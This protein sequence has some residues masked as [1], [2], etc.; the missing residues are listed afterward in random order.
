MILNALYDYYHRKTAEQDGQLAPP[1]FE[2]KEIPFIIQV[3]K[4]GNLIQIEDTREGEGKKKIAKKFLLPQGEKK[5]SNVIANLFWDNAEYVLGLNCKDKPERIAKQHQA[6]IARLKSLPTSALEDI[7]LQAMLLFLE[8]LNLE[9][10]QVLP[11]W[12]ALKTNPN[13]TFRLQGEPQ[14]ICQR[15]A[16][17][18][19]LSKF[20]TTQAINGFCLIS[21]EPDQIERLHTSIKGVRGTKSSG[22]NIVS[23]N[24]DSFNSYN[25]QQGANAPVGKNAVFA[26]TTALNHLLDKNSTQRLQVGDAST[27]FWSEKPSELETQIVDIFGEPTKDEPDR[28]TNAL[29]S[30]YQSINHGLLTSPEGNQRFHVLGLSPNA[31]RISIRFWETA[32]IAEL[33]VRIKQHFDDLDI[34]HG[35][36][37]LPHL[38]L[39][40]LLVSTISSKSK[41]DNIPPNLAGDTLRAILTGLPYPQ[42]LLAA[43]V[44]RNR[45][46]REITYPR[47]A[48]IKACI[49]RNIRFQQL[50]TK[51][52]LTVS[53]DINNPN[54]GYRLGRLFA[55]LEKIQEEAS[56]GLNSTI[57]DRYYG[58]AS[59]TPV[60]VFSTL[61]KLKNHHLP[62]L[63]KGRSINLDRLSGEI[64]D[65][66]EDFPA[67]LTLTDQ[68]RFAIGYYH[69]RQNFFKKHTPPQSGDQP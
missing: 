25:K 48:L 39:Y 68:G 49:N 37:Q 12:E 62:K 69:Q 52:Y 5:A 29:R 24:K 44:R 7:G 66:I 3:D 35:D 4:H 51:E 63:S 2:W 20:D 50:P 28:N 55:V 54:I 47:A 42:T 53:L 9:S 13:I 17:K 8:Q 30:L 18:Q 6:F 65:G 11:Q 15:A 19:A 46:E 1:G 34:V 21:G 60:S 61:L 27:V 43:V 23:F 10:L 41:A 26:Y 45:A 58:A 22:G 16:I 31:A 64:I 67:I 40:R 32:T 56:P 57:R 33:A 36:K 59:S 14:L 38:P